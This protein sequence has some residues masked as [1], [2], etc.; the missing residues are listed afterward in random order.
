VPQE[1]AREITQRVSV[2]VIGI[3]SGPHTSG[4][5][6]ARPRDGS[7]ARRVRGKGGGEGRVC[8]GAIRPVSKPRKRFTPFPRR[9]RVS[10]RLHASKAFRPVSTPRKRFTPFPRRGPQ[11][12]VYHDLLGMMQHPHHAKVPPTLFEDNPFTCFL[13]TYVLF[14][15]ERTP[16]ISKRLDPFSA[17]ACA[18]RG[19]RPPSVARRC[20]ARMAR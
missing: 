9:E 5:A 8:Q 10:P 4:Q 3:G 20:A 14:P 13:F 17:R 12:L 16:R 11:V 6:R 7:R 18:A 19:A 15:G 1:V 2:P